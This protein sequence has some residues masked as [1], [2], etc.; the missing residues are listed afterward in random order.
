MGLFSLLSLSSLIRETQ[1]VEPER[2][3]GWGGQAGLEGEVS[4]GGERLQEGMIH[5]R[6]RW[7]EVRRD[8]K[9]ERLKR[10]G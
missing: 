2:E 1:T 9:R 7:R 5:G 10:T 4:Q 8:K 6:D 3:R